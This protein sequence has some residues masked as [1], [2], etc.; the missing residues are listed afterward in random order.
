M[1]ATQPQ[2]AKVLAFL[3]KRVPGSAVVVAFDAV[4]DPYYRC[5]CHPD[6]VERL[7]N[8]LGAALPADCRCIVHGTPALAHPGTGVIIG[9]GIGTQ[10]GLR[11]PA[12]LVR[13]AVQA[14]AMKSTRWSGGATMAIDAELGEDW[15]FGA[16]LAAE[17][18]W[19][20]AAYRAASNAA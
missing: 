4:A 15:V 2:N 19:C 12:P 11:V 3:A 13:Q 14:G 10:Y 16:W 5:G 6:I 18:G 17:S 1:L 9:V 20:D 7:W 8:Q